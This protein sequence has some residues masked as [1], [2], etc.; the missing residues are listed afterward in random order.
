MV[1]AGDKRVRQ[2]SSAS[3][4]NNIRQGARSVDAALAGCKEQ[5]IIIEAGKPAPANPGGDYSSTNIHSK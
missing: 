3:L 4:R 5:A 1:L 2:V